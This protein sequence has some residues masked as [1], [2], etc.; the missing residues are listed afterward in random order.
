VAG[1]KWSR[2]SHKLVSCYYFAALLDGGRIGK[3]VSCVF[4]IWVWS[5]RLVQRHQWIC[6][7]VSRIGLGQGMMSH[8]AE[9]FYFP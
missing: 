3:G 7:F 6:F 9:I 2:V 5:L 1:G 4:I 8:P